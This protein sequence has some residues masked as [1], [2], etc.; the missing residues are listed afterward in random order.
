MLLLLS[1][2]LIHLD[3]SCLSKMS[4][5]NIFSQ[6]MD[7]LFILLTVSFSEQK[8]LILMKFSLS[9][10]SFMDGAFDVVSEKSLPYARSSRFSAVFCSRSFTVLHF[11]FRSVTHFELIFVT[12]VR[13]ASRFF[14]FPVQSSCSS[15]IVCRPF[16][17]ELPLLLCHTSVD[18]VWFCFWVLCSV[19]W[20]YLSA[21]SCYV[22]FNFF[23]SFFIF[24]RSYLFI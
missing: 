12:S 13:S 14:F 11:A 10:T 23:L 19:P 7:F 24:L 4:F 6:S 8:F 2:F 3:N 21:V 9:V 17:I 18:S 1:K 16:S 5:A 15:T 22:F 20:K